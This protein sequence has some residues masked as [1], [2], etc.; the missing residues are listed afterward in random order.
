MLQV[1]LVFFEKTQRHF[2]FITDNNHIIQIFIQ[3]IKL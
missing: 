2:Y 1:I 3:A